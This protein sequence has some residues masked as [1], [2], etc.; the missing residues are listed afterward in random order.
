MVVT[1]Y[2]ADLRA[3]YMAELVVH[4][5]LRSPSL[6][7]AFAAVPRERFLPPGPW[8]VE[9]ADGGFYA[10]EDCDPGRILHAVGVAIDT[11]RDLVSANPARIAR[12]IEAAG[13]VPGET[14]LHVGAGLGYF[15][16]VM[17][18]LVGP[19]GRVIAAEIDPDLA[20]LARSNLASRGNVEMT[21]DA[22]AC[23]P[24]P[25]DVVFVSAGIT[26]VP[27]PWTDALV[28]GGRMILPLTGSLNGG[29]LF[30]FEKMSADWIDVRAQSFV[31]YYPCI[32]TR[33][34]AAVAAVDKA[35]A[36]PRGPS[37]R[38]LRLDRHDPDPDC[39]LHGDGWCLTT[40]SSPAGLAEE[41]GMESHP[42]QRLCA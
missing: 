23:S 33:D 39:W 40:R 1:E 20:A 15:S 6:L 41:V 12:M 7:R 22:L 30:R 26:V 38:G 13:I 21:G 2:L 16:A 5:G 11:S 42:D 9:A 19:A 32:G 37:V 18:E 8:I 10:T 4:G 25:L 35:I 36:D 17:A 27:K 34:D 29:F 14:V 31:R 3:A 24:P 28:V